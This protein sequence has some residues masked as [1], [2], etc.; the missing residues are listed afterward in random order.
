MAMTNTTI[1]KLD[2]LKRLILINSRNNY[3]MYSVAGDV[4]SKTKI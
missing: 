1:V 4:T 2:S 3:F